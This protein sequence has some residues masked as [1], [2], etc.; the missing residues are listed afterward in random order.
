MRSLSI[1]SSY[2]V[3]PSYAAAVVINTN[4]TF[5]HIELIVCD[6]KKEMWNNEYIRKLVESNN[7]YCD[8]AI[9]K[10]KKG[11]LMFKVQV[12]QK[13]NFVE[14]ESEQNISSVHEYKF[15]KV[16]DTL[17]YLMKLKKRCERP[18]GTNMRLMHSIIITQLLFQNLRGIC[19]IHKC[20]KNSYFFHKLLHYNFRTTINNNYADNKYS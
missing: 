5:N 9:M 14:C 17:K 15:T 1:I 8:F 4:P 3:V 7:G 6:S 16:M 11:E 12:R 10:E 19:N 2:V 20:Y 18:C 13:L